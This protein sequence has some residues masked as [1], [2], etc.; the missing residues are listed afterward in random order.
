[1]L[2]TVTFRLPFHRNFKELPSVLSN[3]RNICAK[4]SVNTELYERT[5]LTLIS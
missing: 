5:K 1:M 4:R 3:I 2:Q